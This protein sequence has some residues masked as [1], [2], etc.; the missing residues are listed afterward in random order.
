MSIQRSGPLDSYGEVLLQLA[1]GP[2]RSRCQPRAEL[3]TCE[4]TAVDAV[5]TINALLDQCW[6]CSQAH[7]TTCIAHMLCAGAAGANS[8]AAATELGS[9]K[10]PIYMMQAEPTFR[11]QL[12]R[13]V[14]TLAV[15]FLI[16]SG[17]GA[18][19]DERGL[20]KGILH[21][22]D[23][24]PQLDS[25]TK[26]EDVKGVDEA[27]VSTDHNCICISQLQDVLVASLAQAWSVL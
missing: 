14:R 12:W 23:M 8:G 19:F 18:L 2:F 3:L 6:F 9:S 20:G 24:K 27:K 7:C 22:P 26:F 25:K 16:I 17:I 1:F 15:A 21:N 11:A 13:T 4:F 5:D 10:N